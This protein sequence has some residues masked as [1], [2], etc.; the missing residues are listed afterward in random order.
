MAME[1]ASKLDDITASTDPGCTRSLPATDQTIH[2]LSGT[3]GSTGDTL[4]KQE[5]STDRSLISQKCMLGVYSLE[6]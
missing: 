5:E 3:A 4:S 6:L 2:Y 1:I